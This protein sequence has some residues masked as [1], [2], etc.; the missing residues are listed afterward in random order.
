[1]H[2]VDIDATG[3]A[4]NEI[5]LPVDPSIDDEFNAAWL[6]TGDGLVVQRLEEGAPSLAAWSID[7]SSVPSEIPLGLPAET[8]TLEDVWFSISPDGRQ[9][10]MW[11]PLGSSWLL[12]LDGGPAVP[13]SLAIDWDASWQRLAP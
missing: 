13:T 2:I 6:P 7:G 8:P 9:V 10:A 11:E 5:V 4:T 1:M 12:P 3:G